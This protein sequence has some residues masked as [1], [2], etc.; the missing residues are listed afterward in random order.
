MIEIINLLEKDDRLGVL[1]PPEPVFG[2]YYTFNICNWKTVKFRVRTIISVLGYHVNVDKKPASIMTN[3]WIKGEVLKKLLE[4]S[5][6]S[7]GDILL[8]STH[9]AQGNGYYTGIVESEDYS[10]MN[11]ASEQYYREDLVEYVSQYFG[12]F[13]TYEEMKDLL[14]ACKLNDFINSHEIIYIYGTGNNAK[15]YRKMITKC[16]GYIVSDGY[17]KS[18]EWGEE[19]KY[20]SDIEL[21]KSTGIIVCV[22]RAFR[23]SIVKCL[24]NKGFSNYICIP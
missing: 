3:M 5:K 7:L 9:I 22:Y 20:F 23:E 6:Y 4:G 12:N 21:N 17:D 1:L 18:T 19:A 16:D 2:Y 8:S 11:E 14:F 15:R 24:T 13:H 10:P